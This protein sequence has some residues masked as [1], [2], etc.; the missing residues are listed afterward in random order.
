MT[1]VD[2]QGQSISALGGPL[3]VM[4]DPFMDYVLQPNQSDEHFSINSR[5]FRNI[6]VAID[7]SETKES[8]VMLGA[9]TVFGTGLGADSETLAAQ[10]ATLLPNFQFVNAAVPG[11][12]SKHELASA[13]W[14]FQRDPRVAAYIVVDGFNDSA[15]YLCHGDVMPSKLPEDNLRSFLALTDSNLI[16]RAFVGV[17]H[18]FFA[19][20]F[21]AF[22]RTSKCRF[23]SETDLFS[24]G[25]REYV[26]RLKELRLMAQNQGAEVFCFLQPD[27][28]S[29]FGAA[30]GQAASDQVEL[31]SVG[32]D[33]FRAQVKQLL[34][35]EDFGCIDTQDL[36]SRFAPEMFLDPIH[37]TASGNR[38]LADIIAERLLITYRAGIGRH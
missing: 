17:P 12:V 20:L 35:N 15:Q 21:R 13:F 5:G 2:H 1:T 10:L 31:F 34:A 3:K 25:A 16:M 6:G 18:F 23:F 28:H 33:T 22:D 9:S 32:Y 36:K 26:Q 11:Y 7:G 14:N 24:R 38:A 29:L 4:L 37:L 27:I 30:P 8:I 19:S